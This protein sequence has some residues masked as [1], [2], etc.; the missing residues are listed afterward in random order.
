MDESM[1]RFGDQTKHNHLVK[2]K[3]RL[4]Q[5]KKGRNQWARPQQTDWTSE[6]AG[7]T[8][9]DG[10]WSWEKGS[11]KE[12]SRESHEWYG[13]QNWNQESSHS[14]IPALPL[15]ASQPTHHPVPTSQPSQPTHPHHPVLTSQPAHPPPIR[16][17][18]A[19]SPNFSS[20]TS[21]TMP[22]PFKLQ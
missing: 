12:C 6:D 1:N 15:P 5:L 16:T 10:G 8:D 17:L 18:P 4:K 2:S 9:W 22:S 13:W 20:T 21:S 7:W 14:I 11:W 19:S 3:D